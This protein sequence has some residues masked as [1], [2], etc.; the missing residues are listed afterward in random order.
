MIHEGTHGIQALDLLG[1]KVRVDEGAL[2]AELEQTIGATV[3]RAQD[4]GD[5]RLGEQAAALGTAVARIGAVTRALWRDGDGDAALAHATPYMQA[6]GH[7]V[8]GWV[9][10]ELALTASTSAAVDARTRAAVV[11][12][13]RWF[14]AHELPR[15]AAWLQPLE[16]GDRTVLE[17]LEDWL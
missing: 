5:A 6:F 15:V 14:H 12:T 1:R 16:Q 8:L 13:G 2:L 11:N 17:T 3:K 7:V 9:W 10:L 4:A